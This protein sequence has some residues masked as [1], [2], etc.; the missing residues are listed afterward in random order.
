[1]SSFK[2]ETIRQSIQGMITDHIQDGTISCGHTLQAACELVVLLSSYREEDHQFFPQVYLFGPHEQ[3]NNM[4]R[5][6]APGILPVEIGIVDDTSEYKKKV[7][8]VALKKCAPL[9]IDGWCV[10]VI[11]RDRSFEY[12]LFRPSAETYSP[13]PERI[14]TDLGLPIV[15][16]RNSAVNTVELINGKGNRLEVS[17]TIEPASGEAMGGQIHNFARVACT[18][19]E[20]EEKE[21]ATEYLTN[22][23]SLYLRES[24]GALLGVCQ[25]NIDI[26]KAKFSDGVVLPEPIPLID[27]M[28]TALKEKDA[29]AATMLRSYEALLRGMIM[30]DGITLFGSDG[31]LKAFRVFV[32]KQS[33]DE[34]GANTTVTGGARSR[35]F[36]VLQG[37]IGESLQAALFRSQ[38]GRTE[39]KTT[40]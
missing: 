4:L 14:L 18:D 28:L 20:G 32:Q 9:A 5:V 36:Q 23:L 38:D 12:G 3:G 13:S 39:T 37:Y 40:K 24:H 31:S 6:L 11:R 21:Q 34:G 22:L 25:Y 29:A 7:A 27:S 35:A 1:M 15:L 30:S 33:T 8:S 26:D 16:L 19:V 10:Y 2:Q 17:L